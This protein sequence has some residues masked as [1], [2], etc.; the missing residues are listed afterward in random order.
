VY[1]RQSIYKIGEIKYFKIEF[2]DN[3][4]DFDIPLIEN[5]I[6]KAF[7]ENQQ[8]KTKVKFK[9]REI[10]IDCFHSPN[11]ASMKI[12]TEDKKGIV[13]TILQVLDDYKI[14][15]EDVKISTQKNIARDLF[16]ISKENGFCEK[17]ENILKALT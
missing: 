14:R 3:V 16:I 7:E 17:K 15:V 8:I 12:K 11:Y 4:E 5:Y 10:K 2:N 6:K 1:K 13:S 9:K